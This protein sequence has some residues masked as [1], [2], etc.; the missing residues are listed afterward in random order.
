VSVSANKVDC[1]EWRPRV[2]LLLSQQTKS[3]TTDSTDGLLHK[4]RGVVGRVQTKGVV[5]EPPMLPLRPLL[6][7]AYVE[8]V[9]IELVCG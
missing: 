3:K 7:S 4:R 8:R 1:G 2:S 5:P 9:E 6:P